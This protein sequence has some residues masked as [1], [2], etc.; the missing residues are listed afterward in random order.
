LHTVIIIAEVAPGMMTVAKGWQNKGV[1]RT[2]FFWF[3]KETTVAT[4]LA[5]S[6]VDGPGDQQDRPGHRPCPRPGL[7]SAASPE[8]DGGAVGGTR[9]IHISRPH[10]KRCG[11][12]HAVNVYCTD[13]CR[14]VATSTS[15]DGQSGDEDNN[16]AVILHEIACRRDQSGRWPGV[17][18]EQ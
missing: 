16:D 5:K 1:V 3:G 8:A 4:R 6:L 12:E 15:R 17:I 9:Q 7:V 2:S 10:W 13:Y 14:R 11:I 18:M